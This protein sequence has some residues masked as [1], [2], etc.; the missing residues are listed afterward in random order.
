MLA[1][2]NVRIGRVTVFDDNVSA[3]VNAYLPDADSFRA[4]LLRS[5]DGLRFLSGQFREQM[6]A[7]LEN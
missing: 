3:S 6:H 7:Q 2:H 4:V 5:V 1:Q